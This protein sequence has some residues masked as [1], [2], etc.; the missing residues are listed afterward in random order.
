MF[1]GNCGVENANGAKFCK[2]CG[3]SLGDGGNTGVK[4]TPPQ[5]TSMGTD[6]RSI[7][8]AYK[9]NMGHMTNKIKSIPRNILI[10]LCAA[11]I[12][13]VIIIFVAV[14]T[15]NTIKLDKYLTVQTT[16][17]D[18]YGTAT[19]TID[20]A[21]I[22]KKYGSKLS[23]TSA[24]KNEYGGFMGLMT[25]IDAIKDCVSV[26][27][28]K[29]SGLSN[30]E[31]IAYTWNVDDNLSKYVKHK[32]KFKNN[33]YTV[34]G[35]TEVGTFDAFANLDVKFSGVAPNASAKFNYTGSEMSY[36]DFNC[37]KTSDLSNGDIIKVTIDKSKLEYYAKN[38]GKVPA[39]LEKEYKVEG[40]ESYLTKISQIDEV[41][42]TAMQ[43]QATDVYRAKMA[44]DGGEGETLE[45]LTYIGNYLL[46]VKNK[47]SLNS[48]N[49]LY[50][51][52]KSQIRNNYSNNE[53]SYNELNDIYWYIGYEDLTV[54]ANGLVTV[55][56]NEN[57]TPNNRFT[58]D[59]GVGSGW[60]STKSW[61][62]YGYQTIDDLYK[63]VVT[64]NLDS[65]NH[66]DNVDK[67]IA[68]QTVK[69]EEIATKSGYILPNSDTKLLTKDDLKG[70]TAEECKIARNEIYARHGRKFKDQDIQ[71]YFDALDWY[72]GTISPE[73]FDESVLSDIEITNRN[74]IV[75]YE[76][77][78]EY[79]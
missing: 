65:Y 51:I 50:L 48:N 41:A 58:I 4:I 17:Y 14:N 62:Y 61:Y 13:L 76:E 36:Y 67:S 63:A 30:G 69:E 31:T 9:I 22:E 57:N 2:G 45:T 59:S 39:D 28:E 47:D 66:E 6:N 19:A 7:I 73:D 1:C 29:S 44:K 70:L 43:N 49:Y 23:F 18:G 75:S 10:G 54:G 5:N 71:S 53:K 11:A 25:P 12:A 16:G 38:L 46:T 55:D 77:E 40:L 20:W 32:V 33:K 68:P 42:L 35:L 24:A 78:K 79:S 52:Y 3:K 26:K 37:D 27:F 56:V 21:A 64:S 8:S 15:G 60:W 34:T 72:K 74:L